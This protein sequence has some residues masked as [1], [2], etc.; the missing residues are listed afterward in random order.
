MSPASHCQSCCS[1]YNKV[2]NCVGCDLDTY[3]N[4][5]A[6]VVI[7]GFT[8]NYDCDVASHVNR[9]VSH[10]IL[11][12]GSFFGEEYRCCDTLIAGHA[13]PPEIHCQ[14]WCPPFSLN[15]GYLDYSDGCPVDI[16]IGANDVPAVVYRFE[17]T[18]TSF[19]GGS[20]CTE[21]VSCTCVDFCDY[22]KEVGY[23]HPFG[24]SGP[25]CYLTIW[26]NICFLPNIAEPEKSIASYQVSHSHVGAVS[27]RYDYS[28]G[29]W[30][31]YPMGFVQCRCESG[32]NWGPGGGWYSAHSYRGS[33][34]YNHDQLCSDIG[35]IDIQLCPNGRR[36][37]PAKHA[38]VDC[39]PDFPLE[40]PGLDLSCYNL[41]K[42]CNGYA[43]DNSSATASITLSL[44]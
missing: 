29:R 11:A 9:T 43:L 5:L 3:T 6:T 32:R 23:G 26:Y 38:E 22:V 15:P 13:N 41:E 8:D 34:Y 31:D 37:N 27:K 44:S 7:S 42:V 28:N 12:A 30:C 20:G 4:I 19:P 10:D 14:S 40:P 17:N 39:S 18:G 2:T 36:D 16:D 21:S 35:T 1:E 24:Y 33:A 25:R